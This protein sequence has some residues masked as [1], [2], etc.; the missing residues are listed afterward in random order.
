V[1][2]EDDVIWAYR[3][4]LDREPESKLAIQY[5]LKNYADRRILVQSLSN[6][7]EYVNKYGKTKQNPFWH[8]AC[9]FDAIEI[10]SK[11]AKKHIQSAQGFVTNFLGVKIRPEFLPAI[12]A[13][14]AGAVEARPVPANWHADIAEWASCLR[15]VDL[16]GDKFTMLE[17]GCGWGCWMTNLGV[18]AKAAGKKITLYGVEADQH[19]LQ[20]AQSALAD[21]GILAEEFVLAKG[22]AGKSNS[23]ALFPT[24]ES[25]INWGGTAVFNPDRKQ[26]KNA[27]ASGKYVRMP[28]VDIEALIKEEV[29][30][31]F[32]HVDI[33]GVELELLTELFDM[34][35]KKVRYVFI[36]THSKQIEAGL[37]NLFLGT[38]GWELEMERPAIFELVSGKPVVTCDGVQA[39]R[40]RS[41]N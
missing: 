17:L 23:V 39:W 4:Y 6:S 11:H 40:N 38:G 29:K 37:F 14:R 2:F 20:F 12:L 28:V 25:G 36:G 30:L 34:L 9:S 18:A 24:I 33:Q 1:L 10:I 15:S 7:D 35:C 32:M 27:V 26:L 5:A 3:L 22:I 41:F 21:N 16:S 19:H 31:D 13:D 8:Y